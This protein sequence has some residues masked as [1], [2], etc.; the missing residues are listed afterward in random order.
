MAEEKYMHRAIELARGGIGAVDPNPLVGAVIVKDNRIISEGFHKRYGGL[1]AEREA[2]AALSE[3]AYGAEMYVTLEP[4]CHQGKT[5][6]CTDAIIESGISRVIIGSRDPNPLVAGKGA[7]KLEA[8]GIEVIRDFCRSECDRLNYRFF[9]FITTGTP[10]VLMKYAMTADGKIATKTGASRWISCEE[11]R[12]YVQHLR[13]EYPSI[14]AGIG[15]VLA[16]DPHLTARIPGGR[17]PLRVIPDSRL[18]IPADCNILKTAG[19][20]PTI[21][22]AA[23]TEAEFKASEKRRIIGASGARVVNMPGDDGHVDFKAMVK[24]LGEEKISGLLIEGG[25]DINFSALQAG[26]VD[27]VN[28]FLAPKI[29]GGNGKTPVGGAGIELPDQSFQMQLVSYE[30]LGDDLL[31]KYMMSDLLR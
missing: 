28:V 13:N 30:T 5:L 20:I 27:E 11:S 2:I 29:F 18:R 14:L 24:L 8:A 26:I 21:I 12:Q 31:V 17:N 22:V 16:D 1:H 10:Y 3:P 19:D 23:M 6:P 15:T 7:E 4:C 9:K 25:S